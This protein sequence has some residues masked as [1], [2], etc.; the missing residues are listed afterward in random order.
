MFDF[1]TVWKL[2]PKD[3][4]FTLDLAYERESVARSRPGHPY[5]N[6]SFNRDDLWWEINSAGAEVAYMRM[7]RGTKAREGKP[8]DI[9]VDGVHKV[10]VKWTPWPQGVLLVKDKNWGQGK[11]DW[12]ALFTGQFPLYEYKGRIAAEELLSR[13]LNRHPQFKRPGHTAMQSELDTRLLFDDQ[14]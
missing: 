5:F 14:V 10:D 12:F 8:W 11:P 2:S 13:P 4:D 9:I 6:E 1:L 7:T 3:Q